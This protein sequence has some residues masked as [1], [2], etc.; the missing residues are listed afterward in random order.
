MNEFAQR[1]VALG[2]Q[3]QSPYDAAR[4]KHVRSHHHAEYDR[5]EPHEGGDVRK[6]RTHGLERTP[7][8]FPK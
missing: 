4:A 7:A 3:I 6:C 8:G 2:P 1:G 5:G